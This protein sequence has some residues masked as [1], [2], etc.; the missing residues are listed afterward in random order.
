[1]G[2]QIK[3]EEIKKFL[4]SNGNENTTYQNLWDTAKAMLSGKLI[5]INACIKKNRDSQI[6]SLV[7]H[8]K[9]LEKEEQTK[10]K[11]SRQQEVIKMRAEIDEIKT[12]QTKQSMK[13]KVCSLKY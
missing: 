11:T 6:N 8:L 2:D 9:I 3:R 4:E 7:M 1:M 12:K 10:S 5:A 13:Q